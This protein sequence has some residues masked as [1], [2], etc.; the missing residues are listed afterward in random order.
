MECHQKAQSY[1]GGG[2]SRAGHPFMESARKHLPPDHIYRKRTLAERDRSDGEDTEEDDDNNHYVNAAECFYRFHKAET[3]GPP[4]KKTTQWY[5][6][7]GE[8]V[9]KNPKLKHFEG[10]KGLNLLI[11]Y[12]VYFLREYVI[13]DPFHISSNN[14]LHIMHSYTGKRTNK[15]AIIDDEKRVL[16][17]FDPSTLLDY[18]ENSEVSFDIYSQYHNFP[19]G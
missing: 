11:A 10:V 14:F 9:V 19:S 8:E 3:A 12:L 4:P 18:D 1:D 5:I 15:Q 6:E 16:R 17:R 7:C 13:V 2:N